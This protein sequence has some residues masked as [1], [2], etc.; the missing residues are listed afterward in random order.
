MSDQFTR[1]SFIPTQFQRNDSLMIK[2]KGRKKKLSLNEIHDILLILS[3]DP[4]IS[5]TDLAFQF[6]ITEQTLYNYL[7]QK[8]KSGFSYKTKTF[9]KEQKSNLDNYPSDQE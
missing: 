5:K 7:P 1:I 6:N 2:K 4:T 3:E 9:S 8:F